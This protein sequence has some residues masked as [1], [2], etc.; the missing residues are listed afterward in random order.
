M[1]SRLLQPWNAPLR[2]HRRLFDGRLMLFRLLQSRNALY[3][4]N[5]RIEGPDMRD[6]LASAK[7]AL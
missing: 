4:I 2:I 6:Y 7:P 1:P 3:S 5:I